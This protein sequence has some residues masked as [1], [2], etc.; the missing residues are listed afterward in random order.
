M[1]GASL[2]NGALESGSLGAGAGS[3]GGAGGMMLG[4][5]GLMGG[6]MKKVC[7][8][9]VWTFSSIAMPSRVVM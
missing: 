3:L 8:Q 9:F 5:N 2:G 4:G 7:D 6:S 1:E